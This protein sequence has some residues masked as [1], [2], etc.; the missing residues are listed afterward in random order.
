MGTDAYSGDVLSFYRST[1]K[2]LVATSN[3][4]FWQK[5]ALE[6][7]AIFYLIGIRLHFIAEDIIAVKFHDSMIFCSITIL[8]YITATV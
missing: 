2:D 7:E 4:N 8:D 6:G 5:N 1:F 3:R